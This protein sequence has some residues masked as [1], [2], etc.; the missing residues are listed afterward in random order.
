MV[1]LLEAECH[2][3][4]SCD[5]LPT[6]EEVRARFPEILGSINLAEIKVRRKGC[7]SQWNTEGM[8]SRIRSEHGL[9]HRGPPFSEPRVLQIGQ[10]FS[11]YVM[12]TVL[13]QGGM[14]IVYG[15]YDAH[16]NRNVAIKVPLLI[17]RTSCQCCIAS[18]AKDE[19]QQKFTIPI[20]VLFTTSERKVIFTISQWP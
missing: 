6:H 13:G 11:R 2:L 9:Q 15:A 7:S 16:L 14:G 8:A 12:H 4:A 5:G 17:W 18:C 19:W 10:H 1:E 3:R 20:F